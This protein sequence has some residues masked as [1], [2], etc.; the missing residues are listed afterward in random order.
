MGGKVVAQLVINLSP[1]E[2]RKV[3]LDLRPLCTRT[4]SI[5]VS[6]ASLVWT[7]EEEIK[8]LPYRKSNCYWDDNSVDWSL[9]LLPDHRMWLLYRMGPHNIARQ[10]C[11]VLR[12]DTLCT[13][14]FGRGRKCYNIYN[15]IY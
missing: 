2:G 11:G 9:Y 13:L 5:Y 10:S 14:M 12:S 8:L 15:N 6:A 3:N 4:H 1:R 7:L